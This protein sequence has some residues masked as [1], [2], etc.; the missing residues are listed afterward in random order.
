MRCCGHQADTA[1][2]ECGSE[3]YTSRRKVMKYEMTRLVSGL[4]MCQVHDVA[5][6]QSDNFVMTQLWLLRLTIKVI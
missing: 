4:Q 3:I 5:A 2:E 1:F 6:R